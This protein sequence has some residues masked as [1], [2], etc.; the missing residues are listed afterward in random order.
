[1]CSFRSSVIERLSYVCMEV[2]PDNNKSDG[3][4]L[5]QKMGGGTSRRRTNSGIKPGVGVGEEERPRK[6]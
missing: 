1:M 4:W 6:M 2:A 5:R 3:L